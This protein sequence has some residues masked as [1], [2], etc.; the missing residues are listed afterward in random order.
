M[1]I[2]TTFPENLDDAG[3]SSDATSEFRV[4]GTDL[5]ARLRRGT[6]RGPIVD[7]TRVPG[8]VGV[9]DLGPDGVEIGAATT[10]AAVASHPLVRLRYPALALTARGLAT[11]QVRA[12]GSIGGNLLQ[13]TR[14]WYFR[15]GHACFKNGGDTCPAR[16]GNHLY[17][18]AID[19]GPCVAPHPSSIG[20]ALLAY[21]AI[22]RTHTTFVRPVADIWGD[23]SDPT[24]D[25]LLGPDEIVTSVL[26]PP[27]PEGERGGYFRT[28][29]RFE[30]EWPLVEAVVRLHIL[31]G[32]IEHAG[33][34]VG[35]VANTPLRLPEVEHALIGHRPTDGVLRRASH[36]ADHRCRPLPQT[37]YKVALLHATIS[38][39]LHRAAR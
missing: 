27:V 39:A 33:V 13:R 36:A 31:D 14:C 21:D 11:P 34:A 24:R 18:V 15:G 3:R 32:R 20:A 38:E 16:T 10:I 19:Q 29:S 5:Q 4:G 23:G 22:A 25:H 9:R 1:T 30:A 12:V 35:G 2:V 28:I 6:S 26:L 17:G 7:L 37:G 8:L